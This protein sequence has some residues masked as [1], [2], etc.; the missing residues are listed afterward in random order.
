MATWPNQSK[1]T[2][3]TQPLVERPADHNKAESQ[4]QKIRHTVK[5]AARPKC[6]KKK[7]IANNKSQNEINNTI[8]S[9][10]H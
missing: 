3:H 9:I 4:S 2:H 7:N 6:K 5:G 1:R 10:Q 8:Q